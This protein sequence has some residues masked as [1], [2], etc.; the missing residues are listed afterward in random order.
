MSLHLT[1]NQNSYRCCAATPRSPGTA[2]C[3]TAATKVAAA[4]SATSMVTAAAAIGAVVP[5]GAVLPDTAGDR[6]PVA[7]T[8]TDCRSDWSRAGRW[9]A[10]HRAN[11]T[12]QCLRVRTR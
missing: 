12:R 8:A 3:T 1:T 6:T 2:A 9:A 7:C 10:G 4:R 11:A 5:T